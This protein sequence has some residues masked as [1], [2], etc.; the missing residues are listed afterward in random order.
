MLGMLIDTLKTYDNVEYL[1]KETKTR[2]IENYNIRKQSEMVRQFDATELQLALFV[3]FTE[4]DAE[5]EEK[6]YRGS[7]NTDIHPGTSK[8]QLRKIIDQG[9]YAAGFVKNAWYPLVEPS[10]PSEASGVSGAIDDMALLADLQAAFYANDSHAHGN[11]SYSEF[12]LTRSDVRI[13]NSSGVDVSY[14]THTAYV[15][16]AIHWRNAENSEIEIFESY[17][18]SLPADRGV[19]CKMLSDRVAD[20]FTV[21]ERKSVAQPTPQVGDINVLLTGECLGEFFDFYRTRANAQLV[22][23]Q[24]STFKQGEQIQG[25]SESGCDRIT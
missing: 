11:L 24:L 3:T 9:V 7:Y 19:A 12:Y 23:Q 22:Y 21:A 5:G 8:E 18:F 2:R 10:N 1:V 13:M 6:K 4:A 14:A 20:L 16:T 15:E 17:S 25:V